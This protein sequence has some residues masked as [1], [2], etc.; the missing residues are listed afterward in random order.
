MKKQIYRFIPFTALAGLFFS[1]SVLTGCL[2]TYQFVPTE[3]PQPQLKNDAQGVARECIRSANVYEQFETKALFDVLYYSKTASDAY[4]SM[5]CKR[6]GKDDQAHADLLKSQAD[7]QARSLTY[8]VLAD[9]RDPIS[10]ALNEKN[11]PWSIF[12]TVPLV[13]AHD[14]EDEDKDEQKTSEQQKQPELKLMPSEVKEVDIEPEIRSIFGPR[15]SNFKTLYK[16]KFDRLDENGQPIVFPSDPLAIH[17]SSVNSE[18]ELHWNREQLTG[19][20][21]KKLKNTVIKRTKV[22]ENEKDIYWL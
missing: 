1:L 3:F 17:L 2:K 13:Q 19:V 18:C 21:G 4:A 20:D 9:I 16:V 7:D 5:H 22:D 11:S 15:Y 14:D 6:R 8:Y 10:T 12:L